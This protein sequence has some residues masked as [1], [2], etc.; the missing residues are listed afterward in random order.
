MQAWSA[1]KGRGES[2]PI[3]KIMLQIFLYIEDIF[4]SK[5]VPKRADIDVSPRNLQHDF[6]KMW[7]EGVKGCLEL[8]QKFIHL[9]AAGFS[10]KGSL[11]FPKRRKGVIR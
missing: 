3:P 1:P 8:F 7:G 10:I 9:V 2:F 5:T 6:P 11:S 4:D